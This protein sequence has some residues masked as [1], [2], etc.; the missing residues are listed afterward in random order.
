M[1]LGIL[2]ILS[3][4]DTYSKYIKF[5]KKHLVSKETYTIIVD[6]K[7]WL[8]SHDT[9]V[10]TYSASWFK[11]V[12]HA[13][14]NVEHLDLYSAI[15]KNMEVYEPTGTDLEVI[16]ALIEREYAARVSVLSGDIADGVSGGLESV[17]KIM[18][19]FRGEVDKASAVEHLFVTDDI[20][21][22]M[23]SVI[24]SSGW[25]WRLNELNL[26]LG[27]IRVGDFIT[28]GA[29]PDSGKTT[30]LASEVSFFAEQMIE[31]DKYILWFCNEEQGKRVKYR[32]MQAALGITNLEFSKDYHKYHEAYVA[33]LAGE[34]VRIVHDAQLSCS[35]VETVLEH[36]RDRVGLIVFDQLHKFQGM[37][38]NLT[39]DVN[40]QG[41]LFAWARGVASYA[42]VINVHQVKGTGEGVMYIEM[43]QLYGSTTII[44]GECDAIVMLGKPHSEEYGENVRGLYSPKNKL[45]GDLESDGR[46]RNAKFEIEIQRDIARFKG[47]Y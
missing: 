9:I 35:D 18:K 36:Y 43:D 13:S 16:H 44:Q 37:G 34:R 7:D 10:W 12:K 31:D 28:I 2:H 3:S 23:S 24:P 38:N 17:D 29:R 39:N 45:I 46:Y 40:R 27:P 21:E 41:M 6:M 33:M 1:E 11:I 19:D 14:M 22:I 8:V 30:M 20:D 4:R 42:P 47:A 32:V 15:F 26:S 5:I 25:R